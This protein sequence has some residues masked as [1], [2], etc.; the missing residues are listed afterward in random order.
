MV[1]DAE[2]N[3]DEHENWSGEDDVKE[4]EDKVAHSTLAILRRATCSMAQSSRYAK[5]RFLRRWN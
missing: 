5:E 3:P 2:Q 4:L 1:L